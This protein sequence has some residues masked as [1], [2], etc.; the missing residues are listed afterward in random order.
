LP[1]GILDIGTDF[2]KAVNTSHAP[3]RVCGEWPR[4]PYDD[5]LVSRNVALRRGAI[6]GRVF[7]ADVLEKPNATGLDMTMANVKSALQLK[8]VSA[9]KIIVADTPAVLLDAV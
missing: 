1:I 2:Q 3:C 9:A 5:G 6:A 8:F 4:L 7:P